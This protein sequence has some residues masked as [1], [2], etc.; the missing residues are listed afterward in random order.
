MCSSS[1]GSKEWRTSKN[2]ILK[3]LSHGDPQTKEES[4]IHFVVS[5]NKLKAKDWI[6]TKKLFKKILEGR[7]ELGG[8]G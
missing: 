7:G 4:F 6:K 3:L 8:W 2:L 1:R 5:Y